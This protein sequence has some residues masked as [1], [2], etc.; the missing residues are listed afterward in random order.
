MRITLAH[1]PDADDAFMFYGLACRLV[2]TGRYE[3]Q[4]VLAD[5]QT[6]NEKARE[7]VYDV[8]ALSA[9]AY[10]AAAA[11]YQLLPCGASVGDGY[12]PVVVSARQIGAAELR[13]CRL[14]VPGLDTSAY[15]ALRIFLHPSVPVVMVV[16]FDRIMEC[17]SSGSADAGL[18]IHEG[19]LTFGAAGLHLI[20]DLGQ[21]WTTETGL[22]L[23]LGVN[24]VRRSFP[25]EV[26]RELG[27]I[28]RQS[29]Q[30]S[31]AHRDDALDYALPFARGLAR[32]LADCFIGLYVNELSLDL[33]ARGRAALDSFLHQCRT[34]QLLEPVTG[35]R[36]PLDIANL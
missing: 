20:V 18:L 21:W 25:P 5:I 4:H 13:D 15:A 11:N 33:G 24:A 31:L 9:A 14:A 12:G 8:T 19:Q 3:F 34:A 27:W 36:E 17:V 7:G 10:P 2:D 28:M 35:P 30:Y 22:P 29:I 1:S 23:P 16:P 6:L 26:K 32:S